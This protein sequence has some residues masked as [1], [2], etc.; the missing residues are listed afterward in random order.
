MRKRSWKVRYGGLSGSQ[1][2][3]GGVVCQYFSYYMNNG[4]NTD[5]DCLFVWSRSPLFPLTSTSL[6]LSFLLFFIPHLLCLSFP[7]FSFLP[8]FCKPAV[9]L[10]VYSQERTADS[11]EN[12]RCNY[13]IITQSISCNY[14]YYRLGTFVNV[15]L[16]STIISRSEKA[17][18]EMCEHIK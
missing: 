18:V 13:T 10:A 3:S 6:P 5:S 11:F 2:R 9:N 14:L 7:S 4:W 16:L 15:S 8:R 17:L 1:G 12:E